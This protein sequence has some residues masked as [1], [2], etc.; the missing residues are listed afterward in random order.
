MSD[1]LKMLLR[2]AFTIVVTLAVSKGWIIP[3]V[4][5]PLVD[6]LVN[7]VAY[8]VAALPAIYA[9]LRVDNTPKRARSAE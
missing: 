5:S 2:Y 1:N 3:E 7:G 8:L 9:W 6:L 4:S